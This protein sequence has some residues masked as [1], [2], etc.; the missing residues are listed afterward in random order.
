VRYYVQWCGDRDPLD[1]HTLQR[2]VTH[3]L[4]G[5][6]EPATAR[7]RQ[8]A[9]RR[10]A[11]WL[12]EEAEIDADPFLGMKPPNI[13]RDYCRTSAAGSPPGRQELRR[14]IDASAWWRRGVQLARLLSET[15]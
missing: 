12:A 1:R 2:W 8:Q 13:P 5:G 10:F 9:V 11:A 3:L 4:D 6:A 7:I 14:H 15:K